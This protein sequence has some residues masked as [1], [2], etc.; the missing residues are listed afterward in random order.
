MASFY[1][2]CLIGCCCKGDGFYSV[3][4]ME[5]FLAGGV[6]SHKRDTTGS[7]LCCY[8]F[9]SFLPNGVAALALCGCEDGQQP[10]FIGAG[11]VGAC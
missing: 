4:A 7:R 3:A 11:E 10:R 1:F 5:F 6:D 9:L 2:A 8:Q